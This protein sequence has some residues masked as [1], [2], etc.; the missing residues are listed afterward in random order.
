M[1][2]IKNKKIIKSKYILEEL[3]EGT[4]FGVNVI[5]Y[6]KQIVKIMIFED[7]LFDNGK[8]NV[9]IGHIYPIKKLYKYK[10]KIAS[11]TRKIIDNLNLTQGFL[12][13]D[14]ILDKKKIFFY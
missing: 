4:E 6:N 8:T 11:I 5:F 10:K 1:L 14:F 2:S 3:I 13:L 9:P 7:L 12:N